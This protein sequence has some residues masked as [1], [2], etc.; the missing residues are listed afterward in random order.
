[1]MFANYFGR[2]SN[3]VP[4]LVLAWAYILSARWAELIPGAYIADYSSHQARLNAGNGGGL[5]DDCDFVV[6]RCR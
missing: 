6:G 2:E 3:P 4:V 1:M 5:E